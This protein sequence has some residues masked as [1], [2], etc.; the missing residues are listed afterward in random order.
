MGKM[1]AG[2]E[3]A[4]WIDGRTHMP[5]FSSVYTNMK[6]RCYNPKTHNYARYGGRGIKVCDRWLED[7]ANFYKD[8]GPRPSADY[9]IER[10][11]YDKDYCPEN[12][13]WMLKKYQSQ[14][15]CSNRYLEFRDERLT[16]GEMARKYGFTLKR[17]WYRLHCGWTLERALLTPIRLPYRK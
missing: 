11:D 14:N 10:I 9:S 5:E 16:L 3:S 7:F 13:G 1:A 15:Q 17:L 2:R 4:L 8:L 12:C 6:T